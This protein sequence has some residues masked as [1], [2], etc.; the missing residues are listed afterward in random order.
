MIG[1]FSWIKTLA[2]PSVDTPPSDTNEAVCVVENNCVNSG[3]SAPQSEILDISVLSIL[4]KNDAS[5]RLLNVA[6]NED[7]PFKSLGDFVSSKF[8]EQEIVRV[9]N[10]GRK[11]AAEFI[12]L[13]EEFLKSPNFSNFELEANKDV[14]DIRS[15]L[16]SPFLHYKFPGSLLSSNILIPVRLNNVLRNMDEKDRKFNTFHDCLDNYYDL[17]RYLRRYQNAGRKTFIDLE[18]ALE[19]AVVRIVES[20]GLTESDARVIF[21]FLTNKGALPE[22]FSRS[23]QEKRSFWD[24]FVLSLRGIVDAPIPDLQKIIDVTE[25]ILLQTMTEAL[26]ERVLAIINSRYGLCG[27]PQQTLQEI[28]DEL[29]VTRERV[30]QLES[31]GIRRIRKLHGRLYRSFLNKENKKIL[32]ALFESRAVF[33]DDEI[34]KRFSVLSSLQRFS[35][36]VVHEDYRAYLKEHCDLYGGYWISAELNSE[37][38]ESLIKKIDSGFKIDRLN[39]NIKE[40]FKRLEWPIQVDELVKSVQIFNATQVQIAL[41]N[42]FE[43]TI[44]N[45]HIIRIEQGLTAQERLELVLSRAKKSLTTAEIKNLHYEMY[46]TEMSEQ[47][48]GSTL[49]SMSNA[50]ITGRAT[51]DIYQNLPFSSED[52][53]K[54]RNDCFDYIYKRQQY[55]STKVIFADLY[56]TGSLRNL[57]NPHMLLGIL[58]DDGRFDC[59]RGFMIGISGQDSEGFVSLSEAIYKIVDMHGPI[60]TIEIQRYLSSERAVLTV[61]IDMMLDASPDHLKI[62]PATFDRIDKVIGD[63]TRVAEL[64][65]ALEI[66][67]VE[68]PKEIND[69]IRILKDTGFII[70]TIMLESL[71]DKWDNFFQELSLVKAAQISNE[72]LDYNKIFSLVF[73]EELSLQKNKEEIIKSLP[74]SLQHLCALDF[75][76]QESSSRRNR[77]AGNID[78]DNGKII[79]VRLSGFKKTIDI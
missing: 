41:D 4:E 31:T 21:G 32:M 40:A 59:K 65:A 24:A 50:L 22:E 34:R 5:V 43:V 15:T 70:N 58:Q 71:I 72:V 35:I 68:G 55:V 3:S 2:R 77:N 63:S 27:N 49:S 53:Q 42:I 54:I 36:T 13:M 1:M 66:C 8:P 28:A 37:E 56:H 79:P 61:T 38:K 78:P 30:R 9:Q 60:R 69:L 73:E 62:A 45:G 46:G 48:I 20:A 51:Y 29:S 76:L 52:L 67:L 7:F 33:S 26:N 6:K 75:R 19:S 12:F 14:D 17:E 11:S 10:A 64:K 23:F 25:D 74:I 18:S 39:I 47:H 16:L 44:S 57:L